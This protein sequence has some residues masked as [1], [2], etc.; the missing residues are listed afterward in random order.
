MKV[1]IQVPLPNIVFGKLCVLALNVSI[2]LVL[3]AASFGFFYNISVKCEH[4]LVSRMKSKAA[5]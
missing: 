1:K 4:T 5:S 2:L 3:P